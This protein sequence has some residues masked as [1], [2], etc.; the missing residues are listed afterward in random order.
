MRVCHLIH[1]LDRGGAEDVLVELAA[2]APSVGLEMSV[3]ALTP[4]AG[5]VNAP[6]LQA[7]GVDVRGLDLTNRWDPRGPAR[8]L[9]LV[10]P[11]RPHVVHTHLKHADLVGSY[12]ATRL[13]VPHVS[14]LHVIEDDVTGMRRVKRY[15]AATV[16]T[17][18]AGHTVAVSTAT[19]TWAQSQ[20][21]VPTGRMSVIRNGV[22]DLEVLGEE[23]RRALRRRLG[24]PET[25]CVVLMA[26]I[27]RPGKGHDDLLAAARRVLEDHDAWFLLAGDG[28]LESQV[29]A[30]IEA[31]PLL[32]SRVLA[33]G[34]RDDVPALLQACDVVV[35]PS[36][37]DA[38]PTAL[39]HA[40][41]AGRPVV[42]TRVGG[43]PEIVSTTTGSLVPA[44]DAGALA[45]ALVDLV[46]DP[47]RRARLGAAARARYETE[48]RA[49][50]WARALHEL[51]RELLLHP[52]GPMGRRSRVVRA[53]G[54][55]R[56]GGVHRRR[57][58]GAAVGVGTRTSPTRPGPG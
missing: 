33:L 19:A 52:P 32:R 58:P 37:A 46:T 57:L 53:V 3:V 44:R 13:R 16:R 1:A 15:L 14:T 43:V 25:A 18:L 26:A 17:R 48:F 4:L 36:H 12:V 22:R 34:F 38:L 31:D 54:F 50:T 2:V 8:A 56:A 45:A 20:H 9:E 30:T 49:D 10:A 47:E 39:I 29:R 27:M 55:D 21:R 42:A 6:R 40:L 24:V 5:A 7:L 51:Y 11:L 28:P 23:A 35:H 41:A